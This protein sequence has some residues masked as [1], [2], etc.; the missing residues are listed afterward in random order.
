MGF[1][2]YAFQKD[3]DSDSDSKKCMGSYQI[4]S[5][6]RDSEI[7]SWPKCLQYFWWHISDYESAQI[8]AKNIRTYY[9]EDRE[10]LLFAIWLESFDNTIFFEL[11]I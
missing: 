4:W 1:D 8:C 9:S 6:W 5:D 11:S 7:D 2:L 10:L 3:S